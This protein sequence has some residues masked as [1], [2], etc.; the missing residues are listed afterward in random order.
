V[1]ANSID[2]VRISAGDSGCMRIYWHE[3][4]PPNSTP[5]TKLNYADHAHHTSVSCV[6][7]P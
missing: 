1:L 3:I 2:C 6:Y 7:P 4:S 5:K